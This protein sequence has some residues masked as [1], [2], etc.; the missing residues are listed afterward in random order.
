MKKRAVLVASASLLS[1]L[2]SA[3][4]FAAP[5]WGKVP[6]RKVTVFYP[7]AA[8][9]EWV[10][11]KSDHSSAPDILDK[12]RTCAKCHEGDAAE[13]GDKIVAGKPVGISKTV[14][15]PSPL[16]SKAGYVP[17]LVQAAHDDKKIYFRFEWEAPKPSGNKKHDPKNEI[18]LTMMFDASTVEGA[19]LNGCWGTC[20]MDLRSMPDAA[21]AKGHAKAKAMGWN[22][23]V[24][25]YIAESRTALEM[26]G[27]PRGGW[28]K[29]KSDAEIG[30]ALKEGK[31]M[32]LM[33]FRSG[34]GEKPVDGYVLESR[35]MSGGKSLVKAEGSKK[36]S[37]W[38]VTFERNLAG[39]GTGDH[40]I[41]EGK[42]YNFGFAIHEGYTDARHHYVSL[43][44]TFGLNKEMPEL[45]SFINVVKQ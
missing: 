43:G 14:L 41:S 25:K 45:K 21:N 27:K 39:S 31:F 34:S 33:Q 28:D 44:Y 40:T 24:T 26:K 3:P 15:E 30:T 11:N 32:D 16:K 13:V 5:D 1:L 17:V 7:G 35:H 23:G 37:K 22:E 20:H 6:A 36:G 42:L 29:L 10:L 12:K 38:V 18:K 2:C 19:N 9:L 4:T 8:G